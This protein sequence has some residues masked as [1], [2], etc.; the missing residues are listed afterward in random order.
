MEGIRLLSTVLSPPGS[1]DAIRRRE[2]KRRREELNE[3]EK[4]RKQRISSRETE[5]ESQRSL[6]FSELHEPSLGRASPRIRILKVRSFFACFVP[7]LPAP[8]PSPALKFEI[9]P[10]CFP[11]AWCD[12][13]PARVGTELCFTA[14][15]TNNLSARN[16]IFLELFQTLNRL[17]HWVGLAL[18]WF[19]SSLIAMLFPC[20]A[21]PVASI[22][23]SFL[24]KW[25][26][27]V[28][29]CSRAR[30][31][32]DAAAFAYHRINLSDLKSQIA[33][34]RSPGQSRRYEGYNEEH[35]HETLLP[36]QSRGEVSDML[37][38]IS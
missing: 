16:A 28:P 10:S 34:K 36:P 17:F 24:A 5:E 4:K 30:G 13:A 1:K 26:F 22:L 29:S 12:S 11:F 32:A 8:S 21:F 6:R 35:Y 9:S 7:L 15:I 2:T 25:M 18:L 37:G 19:R 31:H 33:K 23:G 20:E 38:T 14:S 27:I 3:V